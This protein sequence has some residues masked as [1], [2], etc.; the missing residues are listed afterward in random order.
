MLHVYIFSG[1]ACGKPDKE[2]NWDDWQWE[3]Q[4]VNNAR[5]S[6]LIFRREHVDV[7]GA[8]VHRTPLSKMK[9]ENLRKLFGEMNIPFA[10]ALPE[11]PILSCVQVLHAASNTIEELQMVML[12][13]NNVHETFA[14]LKLT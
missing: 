5:L 7:V 10:G 14:F 3:K 12:G 9:D 1:I 2:K 6:D 4:V 11:D 8:I 13:C